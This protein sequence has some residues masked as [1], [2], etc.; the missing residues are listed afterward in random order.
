MV[1]VIHCNSIV[2][3]WTTEEIQNTFIWKK[4][5]RFILYFYAGRECGSIGPINNILALA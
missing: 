1:T 3:V 4:G 5:V 2:P